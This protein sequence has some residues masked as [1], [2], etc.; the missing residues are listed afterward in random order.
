[1]KVYTTGILKR[2]GV[3]CQ[4]QGN[5]GDVFPQIELGWVE[6]CYREGISLYMEVAAGESSAVYTI[7][8]LK[9]AS[10]TLSLSLKKKTT[11]LRT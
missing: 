9:P 8:D 10:L 2:L 6:A 3:W 7:Q 5:V 11:L 1:M 4:G